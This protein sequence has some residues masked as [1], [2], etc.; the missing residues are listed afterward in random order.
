MVLSML[1]LLSA[2]PMAYAL[3]PG[4]AGFTI[5][6]GEDHTM[7]IRSD[8][9]LFAWGRN[10]RGQLGVGT[11]DNSHIPVN[12]LDDVTAVSTGHDYSMAIR[13]DGSLWA[14]GEN[15]RGWLGDGTTTT[16]LAP[17]KILTDVAAVSAGWTDLVSSTLIGGLRSHTMVIKTDGSLWAWGDNDRGQLGNNTAI[18]RHAPVK[19][20]DDVVSVSAGGSFSMAIKTDGSL[21]GWGENGRGQLGD[22]TAITRFRPERLLENVV[23][24]TAGAD[25]TMA[26]TSDGKLWGWGQNQR[27]QLGDGTTTNRFSP[28]NILSGVSAVSAGTD[29]TVAIKTDGSLWAWGRNNHG[30]LGNNTMD[31]S[32]VPLKILDDV[33]AAS[34]GDGYTIAIKTDGS[35]WAWGSNFSGQLGDGTTTNRLIPVRIMSD[36]LMPGGTIAPLPVQPG[37]VIKVVLDG[38]QLV[39]DVPPM[40][41][42]GRTMVPF[43]VIFQELGAKV[44][45]DPNTM[46]VTAVKDDVE[47][48][49]KVGSNVMVRN[50]VNIQIDVPAQI[51]GGRTLVPGRV[52]AESFG[53]DVS[54][55]AATRTVTITS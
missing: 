41:I 29:H 32:H 14:W 46:T 31:N 16:R 22:G 8:G 3:T 15:V 51:V 18:S 33:V 44:S 54:W 25:Y 52:V 35:L 39:F 2:V 6:T 7:A 47:I 9:V 10:N 24:V 50:G 38:Q 37:E 13:G 40:M 49:L 5:N 28:V 27:G 30:S 12:V 11:T 34:A 4:E 17:V 53:A 26:I 48:S 21:W 19:I 42:G 23:A 20:M 1:V 43:R 45:W 36:V 55:D